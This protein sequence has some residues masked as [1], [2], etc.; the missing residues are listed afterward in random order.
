MTTRTL[1]PVGPGSLE[2]MSSLSTVESKASCEISLFLF[3]KL[4]WGSKEPKL[5]SYFIYL[6]IFLPKLAVSEWA[7]STVVLL[8]SSGYAV[9]IVFMKNLVKGF[10]TANASEC[11]C[12]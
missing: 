3:L 8:A 2:T 7:D 1:W 6:F 10:A 11:S 5:G 12:F 9:Y 4:A